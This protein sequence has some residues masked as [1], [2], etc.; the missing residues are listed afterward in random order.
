MAQQSRFSRYNKGNSYNNKH[1]FIICFNCNKVGHIVRD[2]C[3][4]R[5]GCNQKGF[6]NRTIN[7]NNNRSTGQS[8]NPYINRTQSR[9][10]VNLSNDSNSDKRKIQCY[11]CQ[12]YGHYAC[13]C[14]SRSKSQ[15]TEV[16]Q[17]TALACRT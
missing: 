9:A 8:N 5:Q 17:E 7:H 3:Q 12:K 16:R 6:A 11:V 10:N 1:V 4:K 15:K 13:K 14:K 2:C